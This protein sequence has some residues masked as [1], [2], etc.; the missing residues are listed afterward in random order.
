MNLAFLLPI[1]M[2]LVEKVLADLI[3]E[4]GDKFDAKEIM[5][6]AEPKIR[7]AIPGTWFDDIC[8]A[9]VG[10]VLTTADRLLDDEKHLAQV[11][12]FVARKDFVGAARF[13]LDLALK[14]I[15]L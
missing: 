3:E 14:A 13:I 11:M 7:E 2:P 4:L 5:K 15:F 12:S 10:K 9:V 1:L 6:K 8:V